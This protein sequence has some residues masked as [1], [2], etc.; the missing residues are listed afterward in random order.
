MRSV[1]HHAKLPN[2]GSPGKAANIREP[3]FILPGGM[4]PVTNN[5]Y[6][7]HFKR[8]AFNDLTLIGPQF[9]VNLENMMVSG[10][11]GGIR[12]KCIRKQPVLAT[13]KFP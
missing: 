12:S 4:S 10:I 9:Q 1:D 5:D 3:H 2:L 7:I 13:L 8:N 11:R 6:R